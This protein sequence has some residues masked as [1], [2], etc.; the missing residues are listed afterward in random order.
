MHAL[1]KPEILIRPMSAEDI[2]PIARLERLCFVD[3]WPRAS[4]LGEIGRPGGFSRVLTEAGFVADE[5][6]LANLAVAPAHRG[7]RFAKRML[8]ELIDESYARGSRHVVLEVRVSNEPA[9]RLYES[10]HFK[11]VAIRK[12]YY[13]RQREDALVMI[14]HLGV[15]GESEDDVDP[16]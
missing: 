13:V 11:P 16:F 6:H 12:N 8:R 10:F 14:R 4:F 9:V 1:A 5:V 7:K 15:E 3:P 2:E